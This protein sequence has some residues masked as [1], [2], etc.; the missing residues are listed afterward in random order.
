MLRKIELLKSQNVFWD[1]F[2]TELDSIIK[3]ELLANGSLQAH[4]S[5]G[6]KR[7]VASHFILRAAYCSTEEQRRWFLTQECAL[8]R[9]RLEKVMNNPKAF[10]MF[11]EN[12]SITFDRIDYAEKERLRDKL[13]ACPTGEPSEKGSVTHFSLDDFAT[14]SFYKVPFLQALDLVKFRLV[15]IE[16]GYAY[17]PTPR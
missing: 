7:D 12:V 2:R 14:T 16:R 5:E 3:K 8:F 10:R 17:V 4:T 15:Y 1:K 13:M 9:H 6:K 11:L